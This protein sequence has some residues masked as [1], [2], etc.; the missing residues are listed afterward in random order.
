MCVTAPTFHAVR[1]LGVLCGVQFGPEIHWVR[2]GPAESNYK[3][4]PFSPLL[5]LGGQRTDRG[6]A[7]R[8]GG[9][10]EGRLS[11]VEKVPVPRD[12]LKAA[13]PVGESAPGWE[14]QTP[15]QKVDRIP[16]PATER[17]HSA[18]ET[19]H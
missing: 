5:R 13:S 17:V 6:E 12:L 15:A 4:I 3:G 9:G 1:E 7:G 8:R 14:E 16:Q 10:Q 19:R 2:F 18:G 11:A